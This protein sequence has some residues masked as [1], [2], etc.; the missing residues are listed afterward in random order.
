MADAGITGSK[1]SAL[2]F[3]GYDR[4]MTFRTDYDDGTAQLVNISTSGCAIH[5][6]TPELEVEQKILLTFELDRPSNPLNIR[7]VV[8]RIDGGN[9]ALQFQHID[10]NIKRRIV[11]FFAKETRRQKSELKSTS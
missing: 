11:R 10:E 7:A 1:R 6:A 5:R 2:R 9:I 4:P 8:I 3:A